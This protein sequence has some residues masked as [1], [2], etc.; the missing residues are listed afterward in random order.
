MRIV[1]TGATGNI[2]TGV[3]R[4]LRADPQVEAIVGLARRPAEGVVTADVERDDLV[5]LFRGADAVVHL[6]WLFQPTR[7]PERTWRANVLGSL[8]VFDAVA[9]AGVPKLVHTSSIGAYSPREDDEPVTEDWPTH[10]WPGAAY[11]REKAYLERYLDAFEARHP[12]LDVVRLRPGFVF[13]RSAATAQRRL[14]AG[15]FL[16]GSL[17]RP[18]LIPVVPDVPGLRVQVVHTDDL[19]DAVRRAVTRPVRGP[20]NIATGPVVDPR[21]VADLLGA[22]TVPVPAAA[23]RAAVAAAWRLHAV[24]ASPG[25]FD[26]VMRLPVLDTSRAESALDWRPRHDAAFALREFLAGLRAGAGADTAPLA[27]DRHRLHEISTGVGREP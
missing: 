11:T 19:A 5:P 27:P 24:P 25:L 22:R 17:V 23:V 4:A 18:G 26:A 3:V 10:G 9:A 16:P 6:A 2:G 14:F 7:R 8:R 1:V 13:Q 21:F 20:F 15:P 12:K